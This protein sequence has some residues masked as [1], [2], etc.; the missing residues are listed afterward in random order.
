M[1]LA[2]MTIVAL[3]ALT[4]AGAWAQQT[5]AKSRAAKTPAPV[6]APAQVPFDGPAVA[7]TLQHNTTVLNS[8]FET[9]LI[10]V[11]TVF[12][13]IRAQLKIDG[14]PIEECAE[15]GRSQIKQSYAELKGLFGNRKPPD[16]LA[17]WRLEW[18][19]AFD[20]TVPKSSDTERDV[21]TRAREAKQKAD[22][23]K[24]KLEF[25]LE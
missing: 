17:E 23:A 1:N 5:P 19:A 11:R 18:A 25:T 2:K 7:S 10:G 3:A 20:A 6:A 16:E 12:V 8:R 9:C 15:D 24:N 22:R 14:P 21:L 4:V 13:Q